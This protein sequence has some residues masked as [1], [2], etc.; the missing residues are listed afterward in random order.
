MKIVRSQ[1]GVRGNVWLRITVIAIG[2][3]LGIG[4]VACTTPATLGSPPSIEVLRNMAYQSPFTRSGTALLRDGT[5]RE[6]AAPGSASAIE[7]TLTAHIAYG[8]LGGDETA[9]VVLV[10]TTGG[11][12][13]FYDLAVV[14]DRAGKAVNI[15]RQPLGD[16]V[17]IESLEIRDEEMVVVMV[18]AG[19][20][21]PLCCPSQ[22]VVRR[23][24]LQGSKLVEKP[25]T[26]AGSGSGPELAG[27]VWQW[28]EALIQDGS[29]ITVEDPARYALEFTPDGKVAV[30][31][32]CNRGF[33]TYTVDGTHLALSVLGLTRA[34]CPPDSLDDEFLRLLGQVSAYGFDGAELVLSLRSNTGMLKFI[35]AE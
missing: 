20:R 26:R 16:R 21:D 22:R 10:T 15:A 27:K 23:F 35:A 6:P 32:D 1:V 4:V 17:K 25:M 2:L 33:G 19:P 7:V 13:T 12:G 29:V 11:T 8:R 5:Y 14:A 34:Q 24:V 28:R 18:R 3:S 9:A 31:A 30:R